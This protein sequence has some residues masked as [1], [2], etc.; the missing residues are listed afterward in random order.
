[1]GEAAHRRMREE[2]LAPRRLTQDLDLTD[3]VAA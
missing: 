3:R 2:Y 1:M